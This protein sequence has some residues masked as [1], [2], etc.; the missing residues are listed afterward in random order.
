MS[1]GWA[2]NYQTKLLL[3]LEKHWKQNQKINFVQDGDL[4]QCRTAVCDTV[5][6]YNQ[7]LGLQFLVS[8]L[9]KGGCVTLTLWALIFIPEKNEETK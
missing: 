4:P 2:T 1:E 9:L 6:T 5:K 8:A 3:L 7:G